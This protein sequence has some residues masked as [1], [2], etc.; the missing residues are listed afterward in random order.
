MVFADWFEDRGDPRSEYLRLS[1]VVRRQRHMQIRIRYQRR[2]EPT[3]RVLELSPEEYFDPLN[4]GE[5][6]SVRSVPRLA[7][8]WQYTPH[9]ADEVLPEVEHRLA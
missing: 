8:T 9:P 4:P 7:E 5:T 3:P 6:L 2:D 1:A